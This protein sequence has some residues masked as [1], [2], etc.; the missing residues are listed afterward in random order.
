M[1]LTKFFFLARFLAPFK[2]QAKVDK[3]GVFLVIMVD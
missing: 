2:L 1:C 3:L